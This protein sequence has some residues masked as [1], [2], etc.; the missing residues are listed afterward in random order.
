LLKQIWRAFVRVTRRN[1]HLSNGTERTFSSYFHHYPLLKLLRLIDTVQQPHGNMK[2]SLYGK[3][4]PLHDFLQLY[5]RRTIT[6]ALRSAYLIGYACETSRCAR[7][8][9]N[10]NALQNSSQ[11]DAAFLPTQ[12]YREYS[13]SAAPAAQLPPPT[14]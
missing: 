12:Q 13:G 11:L 5:S 7:I 14:K 10:S 8:E 3:L 4:Y 2:N 6:S 9:Q 1:M